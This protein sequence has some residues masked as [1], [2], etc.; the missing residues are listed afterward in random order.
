MKPNEFSLCNDVI[1]QLIE[2]GH[3]DLAQKF[4]KEVVVPIVTREELTLE[5]Q[6]Q[7]YGEI[8]ILWS[9]ADVRQQCPAL[10]PQQAWK[11]LQHVQ[12]NHDANFGVNREVIDFAVDEL[13][14]GLSSTT[15]EEA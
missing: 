15:S 1:A 9:I 14:P 12:E 10:N 8:A 6:H 5:E 2:D 7:S 3:T 13:Y 4:S 11:V